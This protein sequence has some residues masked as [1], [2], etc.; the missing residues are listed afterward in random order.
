MELTLLKAKIHR[1]TV[2]DVNL[3]YEGSITIDSTLLESAG[4]LPFERVE[5]YNVTRGT[6]FATYAIAGPA[7][8]GDIGVNGAAAHLARRDDLVI[9]AAWAR[10]SPEE[11]RRHV[12]ALVFVDARN[13]IR[14]VKGSERPSTV[15]V[16]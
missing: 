15:N 16:S 4:I 8:A 2:T 12:P 6:R 3:D 9:V 10:M 13:R 11:A 5:V 14:E 1:A 7:G